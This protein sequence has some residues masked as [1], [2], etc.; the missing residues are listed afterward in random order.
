VIPDTNTLTRT[1]FSCPELLLEPLR[2]LYFNSAYDQSDPSRSRID[3]EAQRDYRKA[4]SPIRDFENRLINISNDYLRSAGGQP[5]YAQCVLDWIYEWARKKALLGNANK[6]GV[7]I[8]HWLLATISSAYSQI[9]KEGSLDKRKRRKVEK[10]LKKAADEVIRDYPNG[11]HLNRK[12]NNHLYWAAW[13]VMITGVALDNKELYE[14]SIGRAKFAITRQLHGDGTLP[15]EMARKNK[16]YHYHVFAAAPLVM[17]AETGM[18]NGDNL[19]EIRDGIMHRLIKRIIYE[20][21]NPGYFRKKTGIEQIGLPDISSS[22]FGW[23]EVYQSRFPRADIKRWL[24][25]LRPMQQRRTGG[26]M[27]FLFGRLKD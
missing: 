2:K 1:E 15:L 23:M 17:I 5:E 18:R 8:R 26:D 6:M 19:Y 27:T 16:A 11:S 10:W 22:H 12:R 20:M 4:V 25:E 14:W 21:D 24:K 3:P 7:I 13:A 9:E